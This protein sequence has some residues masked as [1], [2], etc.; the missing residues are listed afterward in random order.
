MR[1][2]LNAEVSPPRLVL[3]PESPS[4]LLTLKGMKGIAPHPQKPELWVTPHPDIGA[5]VLMQS[6]EGIMLLQQWHAASLAIEQFSS[7]TEP[8]HER[9]PEVFSIQGLYPFQ[10]AGIQ[11][12]LTHPST[13]LAD[14]MGLGK[15]VQVCGFLR[16]VRPH[17]PKMTALILCPASM[18]SVWVDELGK[19]TDFDP[20][21]IHVVNGKKAPEWWEETKTGQ[22]IIIMN[23]DLV[24][25]H[26]ELLHDRIW[27]AVILDECHY[28]K[29]KKAQRTNLTVGRRAIRSAYKIALSG[30][31]LT[32]RPIE[33]YQVLRW[34]DPAGWPRLHDFAVQFCNAHIDRW[35]RWDMTG[36]QNLDVL[37]CRLRSTLMM[38]RTKAQVLPDLP[39]KTHQIISLTPSAEAIRLLNEEAAEVLQTQD[40]LLLKDPASMT[41]AE[42]EDTLAKISAAFSTAPRMATLRRLLVLS[43]ADAILQHL[44]DILE[45]TDGKVVF[46]AH[47]TEILEKVAGAFDGVVATITG[48]TPAAVRAAA[49]EKFQTDPEC[50]LFVGQLQAAG[51]GITLTAASTIVFG[52]SSWVPGEMVQAEDRCHR[53]G[54]KSALLIQ[55][56]VYPGSL[57]SF[58]ARVAAL[59]ASVIDRTLNPQEESRG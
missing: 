55:H 13:L 42:R 28:L 19:W 52:E 21:R 38:R 15:T 44:D 4:D 1:V 40:D 16:L 47:H 5:Q 31:P 51:V 9:Y 56:L 49:V 10:R 45:G 25:A 24:A 7:A 20:R 57:D 43:K 34:L 46:F 36:A 32:N 3:R 33:L 53:I 8:R 41:P 48:Q 6:P 54:Q 37:Q 50:R 27:S 2:G 29:N 17:L 39:P 14:E 22:S 12:L 11:R 26:H 30:T 23:Y 18:K 58:I 59:K 35:G